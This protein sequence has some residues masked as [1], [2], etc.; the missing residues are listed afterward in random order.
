MAI[1][2]YLVLILLLV[3]CKTKVQ[4]NQIAHCLCGGHGGL[5]YTKKSSNS[6]NEA[7]CND[8]KQ[9]INIERITID[10][11]NCK[12]DYTDGGN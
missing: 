10:L 11:E 6:G 9:F 7:V 12:A 8:N 1:L 4:I 5:Y 3:S 2:K